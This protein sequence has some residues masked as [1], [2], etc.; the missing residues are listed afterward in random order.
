MVQDEEGNFISLS[1]SQQH[2]DQRAPRESMCWSRSFSATF[3]DAAVPAP[4]LSG[5]Q[6]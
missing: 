1:S 2:P 3:L 5:N 6:Q 4:L